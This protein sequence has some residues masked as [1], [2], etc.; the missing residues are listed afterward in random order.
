MKEEYRIKM[1][2]NRVLRKIFGSKRDKITGG[3][4]RRLQNEDIYD[5]YSSPDI[6]QVMKS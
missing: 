1:F 2:E 4:W 6:I 3:G 5:L